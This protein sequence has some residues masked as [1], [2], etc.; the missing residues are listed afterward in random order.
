MIISSI[1]DRHKLKVNDRIRVLWTDATSA[2]YNFFNTS[3]NCE[4]INF[5]QTYYGN[6]IPHIIICNDKIQFYDQCYSISR[7]LH[8]P[9]LLI[10]HSIKNP[11]Y[12]NDKVKTFN[13][14]PCYHHVCISKAISDS[15]D[16]KDVQILSY[17]SNDKDNINIWKNL[18][19]QTSKKIFRI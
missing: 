11:L 16:L 12:D 5:N 1:L 8:L 6:C 19:F 18:L 9:I 7:R 2:F 17:N 15:W 14:F 10:D 4:L 13:N 3:I